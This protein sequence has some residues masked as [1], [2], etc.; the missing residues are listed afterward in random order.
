MKESTS[1]GVTR[2]WLFIVAANGPS[3]LRL[4][5]GRFRLEMP[6]ARDSSVLGFT[7]RPT[8]EAAIMQTNKFAEAWDPRVSWTSPPTT[9]QTDPPNIVISFLDA[10]GNRGAVAGTASSAYMSGTAVMVME[11]ATIPITRAYEKATSLG[12]GES[13]RTLRNLGQAQVFV[14]LVEPTTN[15][16]GVPN[17]PG[18][19]PSG[20][21][22]SVPG[23]PTKIP[24]HLTLGCSFGCETGIV[25]GT[26]GSIGVIKDPKVTGMAS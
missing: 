12:S 5:E 16:T 22:G 10:A 7:E 20:G 17:M 14:D 6:V 1:E 15:P 18:W 24:P 19:S 2:E 23:N 21:S 11:G 13:T 26:V 25:A 9:F 3:E 4:T 8:R